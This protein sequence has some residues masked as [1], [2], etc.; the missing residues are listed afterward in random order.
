MELGHLR[1]QLAPIDSVVLIGSIVAGGKSTETTARICI[2]LCTN[3]TRS[4]EREKALIGLYFTN[5]NKSVDAYM[6][7]DRKLSLLPVAVSLMTSCLSGITLMGLS[8]EFY[9]QGPTYSTTFISILIAGP[10]AAY[11][12]L[13][14]LYRMNELSLYSVSTMWPVNPSVLEHSTNR[15]HRPHLKVPAQALRLDSEVLCNGCFHDSN[16]LVQCRCY[17]L[18][19]GRC[20]IDIW[21]QPT[22]LNPLVRLSLRPIQRHRWLKS[23]RLD[24]PLSRSYDAPISGAC[25]S[26]RYLRCRRLYAGVRRLKEGRPA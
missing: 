5:K 4:F 20:T 7:G 6:L 25:R 11:T 24:R 22:L 17:I 3:Q 15:A 23:C 10:I 26:H 21:N 16:D 18:A 19:G 9:Y 2:V 13:P 14:V 1:G 12:M 8:A